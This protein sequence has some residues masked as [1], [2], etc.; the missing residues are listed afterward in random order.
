MD[1]GGWEK[2]SFRLDN[3]YSIY[4]VSND[5]V[6]F[7][8]VQIEACFEEGGWG[9][10]VIVRLELTAATRQTRIMMVETSM[11]QRPMIIR[12]LRPARSTRTKLM[13]VMPTLTT[14]I[15]RVAFWASAEFR[16]AERKMEV[17]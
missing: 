11:T 5:L 14:P 9:E 2:N 4:E 17:E 8:H 3:R 13:K 16:P 7:I 12:V 6:R 10:K 1:M 15:P